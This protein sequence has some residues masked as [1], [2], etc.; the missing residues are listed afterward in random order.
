MN[1]F[2]YGSAVRWRVAAVT[3]NVGRGVATLILFAVLAIGPAAAQ[4][5]ILYDE[6]PSDPNGQKYVGSVTWRT[7]IIK[8]AGQSDEV[9]VRADVDI[10]LR[11]FKMT[12]LLKR[13]LDKSLPASHVVELTFH[14]QPDF[15]GGGVSKV[16]GILMKSNELARG[17]PLAG[18][19]VKVTDG[20]FMVGLSDVAA[21]RER[22]LQTLERAWI[23][24]PIVYA[25]QR[26]AIAAIEKGES[27]EQ[28]FKAAFTA[29]GQYPRT[30]QPAPVV[31]APTVTTPM[32][33]D[34]RN[35]TGVYLVQVSSQ[36]SEADA[37]A[38]YKALQDKFPGVLGAWSPIIT[39]ADIGTIGTF[40][41]AAVGPFE[42]TDEAAQFCATLKAAGGQCVVV[43][44]N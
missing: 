28:A 11:K 14:L 31:I 6:D 38:S 24:I 2:V 37:E 26:R 19:A 7:E 44:R 25:N 21:D 40:Y 36:R 8:L 33:P 41:H 39:R 43:Q 5:A 29:W 10:P 42:T 12:L 23:D 32:T 27:G 16:P 35:G 20:F 13:N 9:A 15:A 1:I 30:V 22:N 34:G 3:L 17:T 18:I 4:R